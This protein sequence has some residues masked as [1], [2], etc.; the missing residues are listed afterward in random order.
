MW[1]S[2][3]GQPID[4]FDRKVPLISENEVENCKKAKTFSNIITKGHPGQIGDKG[5]NPSQNNP[6]QLPPQIDLS[7]SSYE[8]KHIFWPQDDL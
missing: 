4:F 1:R 8:K 7:F 2:Y 3:K 6:M 5:Q